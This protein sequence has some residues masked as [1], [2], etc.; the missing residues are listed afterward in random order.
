MFVELLHKLEIASVCVNGSSML[1]AIRPGDVLTVNRCAIDDFAPGE[2]AVFTRD[3]RLFAHRV[4]VVGSEQLITKGDSLPRQDAPVE[5][6]HLLGRAESVTRSSHAMYMS[7]RPSFATKALA[8]LLARSSWLNVLA[9]R[10]FRLQQR[11]ALA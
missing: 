1:P 5:A 6:R 4:L 8:N 3:G 7:N 9:Q 11:L 10:A 2:V